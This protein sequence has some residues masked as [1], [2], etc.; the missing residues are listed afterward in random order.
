MSNYCV[1]ND[2]N[3][4][5][6]VHITYMG[7]DDKDNIHRDDHPTGD[8][9]YYWVEGGTGPRNTFL[10]MPA[11]QDS[12]NTIWYYVFTTSPDSHD[13]WEIGSDKKDLLK[14]HEF[15]GDDNQKFCFED[16]GDGKIHI[17]NKGSG[18]YL[19]RSDDEC[20]GHKPIRQDKD[21]S[22]SKHKFKL[23]FD[24]KVYMPDT[25]GAK[26]TDENDLYSAVFLGPVPVPP[27]YNQ[28]P[29]PPSKVLIGET[30]IPFFNVSSD[31]NMIG[32]HLRDWQVMNRPYYRFRREQQILVGN[33]YSL[34]PPLTQDEGW[35]VQCGMSDT[36]TDTFMAKTSLQLGF[37]QNKTAGFDFDGITATKSRGFSLQWQLELSVTVSE[38]LTRTGTW[39]KSGSFDLA[40]EEKTTYVVWQACDIWTLFYD[41]YKNMTNNDKAADSW[42]LPSEWTFSSKFPEA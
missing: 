11:Q 8:D 9:N 28:V 37:N 5:Y 41:D 15:T 18:Y 4:Q 39:T 20:R 6:Y 30:L 16:A 12:S 10:L 31:P 26:I 23:T 21:A 29:S 2:K 1:Q 34:E 13:C 42:K 38:A 17:L 36:Q 25:E 19:Y 40:P 35:S 22:S 14:D 3:L 7:N 33:E 32:D 27:A 24:K